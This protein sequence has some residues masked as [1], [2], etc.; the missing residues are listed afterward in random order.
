[1]ARDEKTD[2]S[3]MEE[4]AIKVTG[5]GEKNSFTDNVETGIDDLK[6][7]PPMTFKRFM[8]LL[9]LVWLMVTS[10]TPIIFITAVLCNLFFARRLIVAYVV[11]DIGGETSEAWLGTASTVATA[12]IA[13]FAGAISDLIGRRYVALLG[14]ALIIIG[15]IVVGTARRMDV[16]IGGTAIVGVGG[17][18]AEVVGCAGILEMAPVKSRGK[19]MGT[20]F[21][22][23]LP[24]AAAQAY[25]TSLGTR[26]ILSSSIVHG[27]FDVAMGCVDLGHIVRRQLCHALDLL[28]ASTS[29]KFARPHQTTN[30]GTD[31]LRRRHSLYQRLFNLSYRSSMGR[32][33]LVSNPLERNVSNG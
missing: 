8:V 24:F 17:G 18:L 31:R 16:A 25:G 21:L 11:A 28:P 6:A 2:V 19:Y 12:A 15:M 30:C 20:V 4:N 26:L 27:I 22:F 14:S 13:P 10:A 32:S 5:N 29:G 9:S 33:K 7:S 3:I 1:M 23:N